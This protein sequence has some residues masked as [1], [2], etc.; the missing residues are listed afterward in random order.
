MK[1]IYFLEIYNA[2]FYIKRNLTIVINYC[3]SFD[4]CWSCKLLFCPDVF[5]ILKIRYFFDDFIINF[6]FNDYWSYDTG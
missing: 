1:I 4:I 5:Y 6:H 2:I 3:F